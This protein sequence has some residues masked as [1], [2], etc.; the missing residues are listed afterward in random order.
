V[1]DVALF[2]H[3]LGA[4]LLRI[5]VALVGVGA[6]LVLAFGLW[7]VRLGAFGFGAG[8]IDA[9]LALYAVALV[10]DALGRW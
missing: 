3:L 4:L 9:A 6:L 8:W 5:G 1:R 2:F 7:L 10:L